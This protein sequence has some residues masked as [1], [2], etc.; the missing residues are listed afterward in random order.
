MNRR[1][2][3][4][5]AVL[6]VILGASATVAQDENVDHE[7]AATQKEVD[8]FAER[9]K[10][11]LITAKT[12]EH[13]YGYGFIMRRLFVY[14]KGGR[15]FGLSDS[16]VAIIKRAGHPDGRT[17]MKPYMD[18]IERLVDAEDQTVYLASLLVD[19]R[20]AEQDALNDFY[21]S[22]VQQLSK[23]GQRRLQKAYE[24]EIAKE[25]EI[26]E[27]ILLTWLQNYQK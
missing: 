15:S 24:K 14:A 17:P 26:S 25:E 10:A 27:L 21:R 16:D 1:I 19:A 18:H 9:M 11:N 5:A 12:S 7:A 2:L 13:R 23:D 3:T 20:I 8:Y 22:I 4:T 6:L